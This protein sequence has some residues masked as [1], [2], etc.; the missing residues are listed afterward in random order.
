MTS[1]RKILIGFFLVLFLVGGFFA[2]VGEIGAAFIYWFVLA[3]TFTG[4]WF[5]LAPSST[6][7]EGA[8]LTT[9]VKV[10]FI[11][12]FKA[13]GILVLIAILAAV[14]GA[15]ASDDPTGTG[16][17][18]GKGSVVGLLWALIHSWINARRYTEYSAR[19]PDGIDRNYTAIEQMRQD[20]LNGTITSDWVVR[21][22]NQADYR[23][24]FAVLYPGR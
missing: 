23:P 24:L 20:F 18:I 8:I 1:K 12:F 11:T 2:L 19:S 14:A 15:L 4:I 6:P 13:I 22:H 21:T 3:V 10:F 7:K 16:R 9:K 5:L 17:T